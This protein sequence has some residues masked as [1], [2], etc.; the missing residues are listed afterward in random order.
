MP[1]KKVSRLARSIR[2]AIE[3]LENRCLLS[4]NAT[5]TT[6]DPMPNATGIPRDSAVTADFFFPNGALNS[7]TVTN[8]TVMLYRTSDHSPV[9]AVVNT[10]GG[11]D[12]VILQPSVLL[13]AD[14]SYTFQ[15]TNGVI[16]NTGATVT[17]FSETFTTGTGG[18]TVNPNIAFQQVALPNTANIPFTTVRVGPDHA[19]WAGAEDGRIF[20]YPINADGTLGTAQ[21]I[22]SLQ[23]ANNGPR[24]LTGFTFDPA[25]TASNPI[26]WVSNGA[27]TFTNAPDFSSKI[28]RMSGPG[29]ATVQ[30]VVVDLPRSVS[31]HLTD[32][33]VFGPDGAL[34]FDQAAMNSMGGQDI[35]WGNRPEHLLSAAILRLDTTAALAL[36]HPL[37][38]LTPDAGGTYNP[39]APGAPLTIYATG[40]RNAFDLLWTSDGHLLAPVNGASAGGNTPAGPGVPALTQVQQVEPDYL[41]NI[42]SGGYYGHPDPVRNQFVLD[43]GNP[44]AG[45]DPA[46]ITAYPVGTQPD[47][48]YQFPVYDF[49]LH[50]SADGIIQYTGNAFGGALNGMILVTE[51]S[52]GDDI[53][54]LTPGANGRIASAQ[55]NIAGLSG[56][57]NPLNLAEDPATGFLY[58]AELGGQRITLLV[59]VPPHPSVT[60]NSNVIAFNSVVAGNAGAGPS[61]AESV[62][63]GNTGTLPLTLSGY[64]I[65]N[66]PSS[67]TQDAS[68]FSLTSQPATVAPGGSVTVS[69]VY[70]ATV[71]GLQEALLQIQT[72]DP[73]KPQLTIQLHGI[74]AQGLFGTLEPSLVQVLRANDI[75]TIVGA[76]PNDV[77]INQSQYPG[78]P[79][80]SSTEVPMQRLVKAGA[81]PVTITPLA[82]FNSS[83]PTTVRFGYYTPGDPTNQSE[84]FTIGQNDAQTVNPTALGATSFDPGGGAFSLYAAFPGTSTPNNSPDVHYSEDAFNTLDPAH[85]RKFRFFPLENPDGTMVGNAYVVAVEDYNSPQFNSFVNFVGIIRNVKP[86]TDAVG[87]PV[88]GLTNLDGF[89]SNTR[90]V[91]NR[92]QQP[93]PV[94]PP[95]FVDA[96]HD[97]ATLQINNSGD[98][99]LI[100]SALTLQDIVNGQAVASTNWQIDNPPALPATVAP[101]GTLALKI[102]FIAQSAPAVPYNETNDTATINGIPVT[103]A[104]GVWNGQLVIASNDPLN[105]TRTVQ[106]AGYWQHTSENENEPGMQTIVN[107]LFGYQTNISNNLQP[108]LPNND[109]AHQPTYYGEEVASA[110]WNAADPTQPVSV[111][112]LDAYHNQ[113][114]PTTG[115]PTAAT[116]LWYN[117]GG[118]LNTLFQNSTG[119][120]QTL[121]PSKNTGGVAAG[122]FTPNGTFGWNLDG[123]NSL[124]SANTTDIN[125]FGR[126]G[127]AVRFYPVRDSAGNIVPNQWLMVMD[128]EGGQYDNSDFQDLV[129]L[130]SNMRPAASP[131]TPAD[132]FAAPAPSGGVTIQWS[133]DSY[134]GSVGYDVYR[135]SAPNG[136]FIKINPSSS[137]QTGFTDLNAPVGTTV[138]YHVVAVD[139]STGAQSLAASA[140]A[141]AISAGTT[142]TGLPAPSSLLA[143]VNADG[144]IT[145]TWTPS[146][147]AADYHV[148]RLAPGDTV[149]KEIATG[150]TGNSYT[151]TGL[152]AGDTYEYRI[153]AENAGTLSAYST[154]A[155]AT[156][157]SN[158]GQGGGGTGG[159]GTGGGGG[160]VGGGTGGGVPVITVTSNF[161]AVARGSRRYRGALTPAAG[162]DYFSFTLTAFSKTIINLSGLKANADLEL[163]D[164]SGHVLAGS[165]HPKKRPESLNLKLN[166]GAYYIKAYLID[167]VATPFLTQLSVSPIHVKSPKTGHKR[168]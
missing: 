137:S 55:H 2:P 164:A 41:Y 52:A 94:N 9:P 66:D 161:G 99:P 86:A 118:G 22:T 76:G 73:A 141:A 16:D 166:A 65:V 60:L 30:D 147:G 20:R 104:G 85:P 27:Y 31:D 78:N 13:D 47:P 97:T 54:A 53:V 15:I 58:V 81:G 119:N 146:P 120:G 40:V 128:Y 140:H 24:L 109:A 103:Q 150:I 149:F 112:Q 56:F 19:L 115:N 113:Y 125:M 127:H 8:G 17:P 123:E 28:T 21:V 98:Q 168:R 162:T 101:G 11:N 57:Q 62:T 80:P 116:L 132:V 32:Q 129:Y 7:N 39:N 89:P 35:V 95:G 152:T 49:G 36:G 117:K 34:Y 122:S 138:Y 45:I 148:E 158:S 111:V 4:G 33:P 84:L 144:S 71:L 23:T 18:A 105:P 74:G 167:N 107:L 136:P 134:G 25:S 26:L 77:N 6:V 157:P 42:T 126:T 91:F 1:V 10:T 130:V 69:L 93:N 14:T 48:N 46:E 51:Y 64:S 88:L 159:G 143:T 155:T 83:V 154:V 63:I 139:L 165:H 133:P 87:A 72:N 100:I 68:T 67:P 156:V 151:D 142:P 44:T 3:T 79:D 163:V 12:A 135:A 37:D 82:S 70:N 38:V 131:P 108:D 160:N 96:V 43:G 5:V 50:R 29:L 121:F 153:R 92:I 145:L 114:D 124:D 110:Y 61:H 102:H 59:P 106:L 90:M 75:P